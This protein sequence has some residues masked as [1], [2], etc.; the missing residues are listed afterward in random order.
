MEARYHGKCVEMIKA[1]EI[2]YKARFV[3]H[4]H[5]CQPLRIDFDTWPSSD[6]CECSIFEHF[7]A[8]WRCI[9]CVIAEQ[10]RSVASL[11]KP[12]TTYKHYLGSGYYYER[13][14]DTHS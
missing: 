3:E 5:S 8:R 11:P 12:Y 13:V 2:F 6:L 1:S 9:P 10:A 4:C 14:S 7:V